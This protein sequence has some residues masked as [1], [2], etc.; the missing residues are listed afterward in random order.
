[1][2]GFAEPRHEDLVSMTYVRMYRDP[3]LAKIRQCDMSVY[4]EVADMYLDATDPD[5]IKAIVRSI[6]WAMNRAEED[7]DREALE[8]LTALLV[9][10]EL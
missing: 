3:R 8:M 9:V 7:E 4:K 5:K 6:R 2:K 10:E 1:M